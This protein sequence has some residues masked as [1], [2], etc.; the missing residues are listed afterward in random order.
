LANAERGLAVL[1]GLRKANT[2]IDGANIPWERYLNPEEKSRVIPAEALADR[3]KERLLL[4]KTAQRGLTL[5]WEKTHNNVLMKPGD[6][7][8]WA[9]WS[10]HGK[11]RMLKQVM[12]HAI[13]NSERPLIASM[14]ENVMRVWE[15]L[16]KMACR[17][18]EPT[19]KAID[20]FVKFVAGNLWLYDQQGTVDP[21]KMVAVIRYAASELKIT[22]VMVDSLMML[23]VGRDD[24]EAQAKFVNE[25][26]A[27]AR[28]TGITIHLV[29][30]MRKRDG[31]GGEESPGTIHD[32]F[33]GHEISS[34]ADGVFVVWR[35]MRDVRPPGAPH[36]IVRVDKQRGDVD[37]I[38][39]IGLNYNDGAR[40]FVEDVH[41]MSF[42]DESQ[43]F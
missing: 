10:R 16:A 36:C 43:E 23:N 1:D 24:Y 32:I 21:K 3:V 34:I 25:L 26:K 17:S 18:M 7:I 8:V 11:T 39:T 38:G 42:W 12:L 37:W 27:A 6:L 19:P 2:V 20:R 4:G 13:A 14:E 22:Q 15:D 40:Q 29:A 31:K 41:P 33:G 9:G 35:D 30:H 28:D 5:P